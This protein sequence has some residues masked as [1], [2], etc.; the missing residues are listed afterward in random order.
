MALTNAQRQARWRVKRDAREKLRPDVIEGELL[1]AAEVYLTFPRGEAKSLSD[2]ERLALADRLAD[3]A[4]G[5][6]HRSQVF[7]GA[8]RR[9]RILVRM[10]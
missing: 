9:L 2:A 1:K 4:V 5:H 8:A 7:A 3:I 6:L 10:T